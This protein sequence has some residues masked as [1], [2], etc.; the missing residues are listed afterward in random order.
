MLYLTPD[1]KSYTKVWQ[2]IPHWIDNSTI[3]VDFHL[4]SGLTSKL[5]IQ[6]HLHRICDHFVALI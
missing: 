4:N 1:C 5:Q 6:H 3:C 2:D